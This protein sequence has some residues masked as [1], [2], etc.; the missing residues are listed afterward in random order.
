[1][2][3]IKETVAEKRRTEAFMKIRHKCDCGHT[4]YIPEYRDS[5][6]CGYCY[7]TVYKNE[8]VKFRNKLNSKL[9]KINQRERLK[10]ESM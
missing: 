4:V 10:N 7:K 1:M 6:I 2:K 9:L 5:S 8:Q 3:I